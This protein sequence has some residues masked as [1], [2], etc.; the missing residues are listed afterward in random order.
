[1][2]TNISEISSIYLLGIL[3]TAQMGKHTLTSG[4][5]SSSKVRELNGRVRL[6][7]VVGIYRAGYLREM[8]R[9]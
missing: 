5:R 8:Y 3:P 2:T 7:K 6:R 9:K 1:M 4:S